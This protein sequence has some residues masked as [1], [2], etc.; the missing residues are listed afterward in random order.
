MSEGGQRIHRGTSCSA[1]SGSTITGTKEKQNDTVWSPQDLDPISGVDRRADTHFCYGE[2]G[3][4]QPF[5][6]SEEAAPGSA[7]PSQNEIRSRPAPL[8]AVRPLYGAAGR[9]HVSCG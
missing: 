7:R 3:A 8:C 4:R 6:Q 1:M 5:Q 9:F 2:S